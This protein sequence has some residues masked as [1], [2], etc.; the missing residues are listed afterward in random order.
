MTRFPKFAGTRA[1]LAG[2]VLA[3]ALALIFYRAEIHAVVMRAIGGFREAGAFPFFSAMAILPAAGFPL[4]AF[5]VAAGPLFGPAL[6]AWHVVAYAMLA[7]A[8]NVTL[9]YWIAARALRPFAARLADRAGYRIPEIQAERAWKITLLIRIIPGLPFFLQSFLL[10]V[11]R[12]SFGSY[13]AI[14]LLVQFV[15]L[16]SS[17]LFGTALLIGDR[18]AMAGAGALFILICVVLHTL[19]KSQSSPPRQQAKTAAP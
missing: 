14:S 2:A 1:A 11:A 16:V 15:Y 17:V 8:F 6:G 19:R 18:K 10:G 13:L 3:F 12:V 5:V 4:S 7:V 9:S